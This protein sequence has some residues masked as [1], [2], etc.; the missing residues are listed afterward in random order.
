MSI[1]ELAANKAKYNEIAN[2]YQPSVSSLKEFDALSKEANKLIENWVRV[3]KKDERDRLKIIQSDE[4]PA[5]RA[6]IEN[7]AEVS[8][9]AALQKKLDVL[10][11]G[12]DENI[13]FQKRIMKKLETPENYNSDTL[14]D[15][16][17]NILDSKINPGFTESQNDL[18]RILFS[19]T[20]SLTKLEKEL[21]QSYNRLASIMILILAI[22]IIVGSVASIL[23]TRSISQPIVGL[24]DVITLLGKGD[25]PEVTYVERDD[26]IGEITEAIH[27]MI[28]S[29]KLKTEFAIQTGSGSYAAEFLPGERDILGNAL[30]VMRDN[31]KTRRKRMQEEVGSM[32]ASPRQ[33]NY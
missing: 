27:A 19:E 30:L 31:L 3:A 28:K 13:V 21:D 20:N 17:F 9:N 23:A 4:Y 1:L 5:L 33:A 14:I 2:I 32:R 22:I 12:Y 8:G 25:I 18:K 26:E 24:K 29:I 11:K 7:L 15:A 6:K 16:A 10:L